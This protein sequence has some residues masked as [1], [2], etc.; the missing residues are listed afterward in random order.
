VDAES[1]D[2]GQGQ[3]PPH[4]VVYVS[5]AFDLARMSVN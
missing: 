2:Q 3:K 5:H 4:W 1:Q